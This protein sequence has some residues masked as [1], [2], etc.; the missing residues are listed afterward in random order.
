MSIEAISIILFVLCLGVI[1]LYV[2]LIRRHGTVLTGFTMM[3]ALSFFLTNLSLF[4][5]S[6][7]FGLPL[8]ITTSHIVVWAYSVFGLLAY[9]GGVWLAWRPLRDRAPIANPF[10][11]HPNLVVVFAVLGV[12]ITFFARY[13]PFIPTLSSALYQLALFFPIAVVGAVTQ[14]VEKR[15]YGKLLVTA[16]VF[17]PVALVTVVMTGFAGMMGTF[18]LNPIMV[19]LFYRRP[20]AWKVG[21]LALAIYG[22][23]LA[24]SVWL[25]SRDMIRGGEL[26]GRSLFNKLTTF[27]TQ[28]A[29]TASISLLNPETA[30]MAAQTRVDLSVYNVF[31]VEWMPG[32]EPYSLGRGLFLDPLLAAVPR[33]LWK[34]KPFK[35]GDSE[36][37]NRYTGLVLSNDSISVDT[38]IT[39]ELYSNY[40]WP[41]VVVGLFLFGY[42]LARIEL[43][44]FRPGNSVRTITVLLILAVGLSSG[45]RRAAAMMLENGISVI[46][47]FGIGTLLQYSSLFRNPA[48]A[49]S[50][51]GVA[52]RIEAPKP[53][54]GR[55]APRRGW[56]WQQ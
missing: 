51:A 20:R 5:I 54:V 52:A 56:R 19:F 15:N 44:L 48:W 36:Y 35:L 39:F 6:E 47:A 25:G 11:V 17:L 24:A 18:L 32:G 10:V 34:D 50:S 23:F 40:S 2:A 21:A 38:N 45:G 28:F 46:S 14:S 42:I 9:A 4:F 41:G 43:R 13:L 33:L 27:Y 3:A 12:L 49:A 16:A 37:I 1:A 30:Q 29:K 22:F 8:D 53:Q 7:L 31:Q 55:R 26:E